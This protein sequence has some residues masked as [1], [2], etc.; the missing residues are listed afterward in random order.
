MTDKLY[1]MSTVDATTLPENIGETKFAFKSK[2]D[3][4]AVETGLLASVVLSTLSNPTIDLVIPLTVP[5]NVG[6]AKLAF[7]SKADCVAVE[8]GLFASVVLSTLSNPTIDLVIPP[9]MPVNVGE[10]KVA[11]FEPNEEPFS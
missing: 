11:Y 5:V 9:T 7:K 6:E 8:T 3:C 1:D 10:A 4:V 2:A